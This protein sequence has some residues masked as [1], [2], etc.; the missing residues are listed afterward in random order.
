MTAVTVADLALLVGGRVVGDGTRPIRGL[1]DLRAA[2]PDELGFVRD[3][4]FAE[5][6]AKSRAGAIV[7]A[8]PLDIGTA[9][10]VAAPADV[11]FAKIG[12][13][14]HPVPRAKQ[15][16]IHRSAV[17]EDGALIGEPVEIGAHCVVGERATV[18]AGSLLGAGVVVGADVRIGRDCTIYPRVVLYPG[19]VLGD[20]VVVHSGTVI[21]SD[22]FGYARDAAGWV[23]IPQIGIVQVEDD[24]ELGAN[25]TIDRATLGVT[26]IGRG[27][28]IDN[29]V[30]VGHNCA[31]GEHCAV[32]GFSAFSGSTI[33]GDRVVL[34]GHIVSAG[35]LRVVDDARIGGNS[36]LYG[37]VTEAGDY[38]GY[39]LQKKARWGRTFHV[40]D[41][42]PE[43]FAEL[44]EL[45]RRRD[46]PGE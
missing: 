19:V 10:I 12:L 8:E 31:F 30:H 37:D 41:R 32:A 9:Q 39:P 24:V 2:G 26:R 35:H 18:G 21:G 46:E 28:K 4:K 5:L 7:V 1:A 42:L 3:A 29:L 34:G 40:L 38:L 33:F 16:R 20:R 44:R 23:K 14:F 43:V 17:V 25:V 13:H 22:G 36:V 11:A 6:A 27:T 45:K 15:H